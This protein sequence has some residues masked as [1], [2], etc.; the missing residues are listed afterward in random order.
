RCFSVRRC[1]AGAS[2]GG[3]QPRA[4]LRVEIEVA[5]ARRVSCASGGERD[6]VQPAQL[7]GQS[8]V[9][10]RAWHARQGGTQ[11]P[12]AQRL[13]ELAVVIGIHV[14]VVTIV[15]AEQLVPA[16]SADDHFYVFASEFGDLESA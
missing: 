9:P 8:L 5:Q 2:F 6:R 10:A 7:M 1:Q 15:T 14:A 12:A 4:G 16:V 3:E 13:W 11:H